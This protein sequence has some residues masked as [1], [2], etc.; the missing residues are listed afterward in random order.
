MRASRLLSLLLLLQARGRMSATE[1]AVEL[2]VSVRTVYRD[3]ESLSAAGIPVYSDRGRDGGYQL[4]EG[5]RTRLTGLS[6]PEAR[7]LLFAGMPTAATE[8]GLGDVLA[9]AQLKLSA[10][11]PSELRAQA[12]RVSER[13]LLDAPTWF[14]TADEVPWLAG[15]ADAVWDQRRIEVRYE[16]WDRSAVTRLLE[17]LGLVLKSGVWYLLAGPGSARTFR[18]SRVHAC[19]V[20]DERF[21]RPESFVLA[22][23]WA[24]HEQHLRARLYRGEALV[25][26]S[27][28][29]MQLLFLLG[30]VVLRA[31][32]AQQPAPE[33]GGRVM[34]R[35]PI[36][37]I[38]HATAELLRFG[39][40]IEV[41]EPAELRARII[42]AARDLGRL[43]R[44]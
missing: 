44:L 38:E 43:Y 8:L 15:I 37:S 3:V 22:D 26:F 30:P 40:E 28:R 5:Y 2:E 12:G 35:L 9:A 14:R 42:S 11:L 23:A 29:A 31:A 17:P 32:R 1:L 10:A 16:R 36:E 34:L 18:V 41:L 19:D 6:E 27:P 20:L 39:A 4:L 21:D 7:A 25:R 13:F 33:D 24:D